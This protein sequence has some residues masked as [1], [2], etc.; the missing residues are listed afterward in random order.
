MQGTSCQL[1]HWSLLVRKSCHYVELFAGRHPSIR[2]KNIYLPQSQQS[3]GIAAEYGRIPV[4]SKRNSHLP[5]PGWYSNWCLFNMFPQEST[6]WRNPHH[7]VITRVRGIPSKRCNNPSLQ[8]GCPHQA[9]W[10]QQGIPG[11]CCIEE[12]LVK[13]GQF[14]WPVCSCLFESQ[15]WYWHSMRQVWYSFFSIIS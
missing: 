3:L 2:S 15:A 13:W 8:L 5:E 14:V 10:S 11:W 6:W 4:I 1:A 12:A 7:E 9:T